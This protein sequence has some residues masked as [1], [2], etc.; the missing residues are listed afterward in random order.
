MTVALDEVEATREWIEAAA[1]THPTLVDP[2]HVVAERLGITNVPTAVWIDEDDR[3][4]RPPV[5]A[6]VNDLF[7][8]FTGIDSAV[9]R[10]STRLNSS[11]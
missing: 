5:I 2:D 10:K 7:K 8:D 4:V 9:D 6:P 11:H 3:I 1:P